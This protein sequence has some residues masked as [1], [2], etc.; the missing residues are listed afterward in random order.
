MLDQAAQA[1]RY[2]YLEIDHLGGLIN[3][4]RRSHNVF[5]VYPLTGALGTCH[6]ATLKY[7]TPGNFD[8]LIFRFKYQQN[9][10]LKTHCDSA[11]T[12]TM[13]LGGM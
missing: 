11:S 4:V 7:P 13:H 10:T 6:Q 12:F 1:A 2:M 5:L 3:H 9:L 8:K